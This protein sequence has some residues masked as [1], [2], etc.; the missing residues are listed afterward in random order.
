M[1]KFGS[2]SILN[3]LGLIV[4]TIYTLAGCSASHYMYNMEHLIDKKITRNQDGGVTE[5]QVD[6]KA[7]SVDAKQRFVFMQGGENG[8]SMICAEPS[9]DALSAIV[10]GV[11]IGASGTSNIFNSAFSNSESASSIGL[12]TQSIQLL[13]DGMYRLCEAY[14]GGI[15]GKEETGRR[16]SRYQD[17]MVAILAIES[18]TGVVT[19]QQVVLSGSSGASL[20][21]EIDELTKNYTESVESKL[22]AEQALATSETA[23]VEANQ[24]LKGFDG[25]VY[26]D[27]EKAQQ[28]ICEKYSSDSSQTPPDDTKLCTSH[29]SESEAFTHAQNGV[30]DAEADKK[31]KTTNLK[32][33]TNTSNT[34]NKLLLAAQTQGST[35]AETKGA[36]G[37]SIEGSLISDAS[38]QHISKAVQE[39]VDMSLVRNSVVDECLKQLENRNTAHA[40]LNKNALE[41]NADLQ[42]SDDQ[43]RSLNFVAKE[44]A[45]NM[46]SSG[47][48]E[49]LIAFANRLARSESS[50][51]QSPQ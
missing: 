48:N 17:T 3:K 46:G 6:G 40:S 1:K 9:P 41:N 24:K 45:A 19:P 32:A 18:L 31:V 21:G 37:A 5:T 23:L 27:T 8:N 12:R 30:T 22:T 13:R 7:I 43:I 16:M 26:K 34:L 42:L 28:G 25:K 10:S 11:T 14:F 33:R 15:I 49:I 29:M 35:F 2:I 20:G 36:F 38:A 50:E 4:L 47:C 44:A 51:L 39:I